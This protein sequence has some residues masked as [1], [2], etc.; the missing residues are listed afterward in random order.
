ML[1]QRNIEIRLTRGKGALGENA[2]R[3]VG[4]KQLSHSKELA[5]TWSVTKVT[6][7]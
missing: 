2:L 3:G 1:S 6:T 7:K 5:P 4:I